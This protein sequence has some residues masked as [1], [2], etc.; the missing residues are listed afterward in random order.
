MTRKWVMLGGVLLLLC[1][2]QYFSSFI[3]FGGEDSSKDKTSSVPKNIIAEF[4]EKHTI[5]AQ[6]STSTASKA[7]E[8][9]NP[10]QMYSPWSN[11]LNPTTTD[12]TNWNFSEKRRCPKFDIA[13]IPTSRS[14]YVLDCSRSPKIALEPAR[15]SSDVF[16]VDFGDTCL[17]KVIKSCC[18]DALP[19]PN[20][21]HYVWYGNQTLGY[22]PFLSYISV[23]RFMKP[24]LFLFHGDNLPRGP[25]WDYF[26]AFNP[27]VIHVR[28]PLITSVFGQKLKFK[29]HGADL[30]RIEAIQ[31]YGGVYL[32]W[33]E[34]LLRS[35]EPL[36]QYDYTQGQAIPGNLGNQVIMGK[37]NATFLALWYEGYRNY[38][39]VWGGNSLFYPR[40]LSLMYPHLIHVEGFNFT[41]PGPGGIGLIQK[42][43]YDWTTNY[44]I[45]LYIRYYKKETD[46]DIIKSLNTTI[47]SVSRH[48]LFGDKELCLDGSE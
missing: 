2:T 8:D 14:K 41:K 45:H 28:R 18:S 26:I 42:E 40:K 16:R 17:L 13:D 21:V 15:D 48:V 47:G 5:S 9:G 4:W 23:M 19:V 30:M 36:R 43:N 20:I 44:A 38:T 39:G 6:M 7:K 24:C 11:V 27:N 29:E 25:Y 34:I 22:F 1:V 32:D 35:L 37:R 10:C 33:D 12:L 3:H 31:V 46:I